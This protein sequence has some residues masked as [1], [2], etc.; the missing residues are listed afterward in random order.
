MRG[1]H[2]AVRTCTPYEF[3]MHWRVVPT[4]VPR[5]EAEDVGS[6]THC[7]LTA[8]GSRMLHDNPD[9][10]LVAGVHYEL[11]NAFGRTDDRDW[12]A[13]SEHAGDAYHNY[14]LVRRAR[15]HVPV[16]HYA[17]PAKTPTEELNQ[18]TLIYFRPWVTLAQE[19]SAHVPLAGDL[20][21]DRDWTVAWNAYASG[22]VLHR[23]LGQWI[24]NFRAVHASMRD[25][26]VEL[27]DN[28]A[29]DVRLPENLSADDLLRKIVKDPARVASYAG[30]WPTEPYE[31]CVDIRC[32]AAG[33]GAEAT[34]QANAEKKAA[35][36]A[37]PT[38]SR[39][40]ASPGTAHRAQPP[41]SA[42]SATAMLSRAFAVPV[43][44]A[45]DRWWDSL[46]AREP[47]GCNGCDCCDCCEAG[48]SAMGR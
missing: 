4:K 26:G 48:R 12:I 18:R 9:V 27:D 15:P 16:M 47:G 37:A 19:A 23:G 13:L 44:E 28:G 7:E 20:C 2:P 35:G 31:P 45:I 36:A 46:R 30:L 32:R 24:R 6:R 41:R 1:R 8:E 21:P 14:V 3:E 29:D 43:G 38:P 22:G 10:D 17:V 39:F 40:G 25:D 34:R 5:S 42:R 33:S 11:R